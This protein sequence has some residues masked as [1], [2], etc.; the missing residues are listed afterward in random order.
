MLTPKADVQVPPT[1]LVPS[2]GGRR[3][4]GHR[5]VR[6]AGV[7]Q[8]GAGSMPTATPPSW[9][10]CELCDRPASGS[11]RLVALFEK[12]EGRDAEANPDSLV[13]LCPDC[14]ALA[15]GEIAE[16]EWRRRTAATGG[17]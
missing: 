16:A 15:R 8:P 11:R 2:D 1:N 4:I 9:L 3:R 14:C 10:Q 6:L 7:S 13:L 5:R 17:S 12:Q